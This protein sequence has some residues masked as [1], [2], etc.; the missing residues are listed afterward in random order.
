MTSL[1]EP[2]PTISTVPD[3]RDGEARR[4]KDVEGLAKDEGGLALARDTLP[5]RPVE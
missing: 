5:P 2:P 1:V 3:A 4:V